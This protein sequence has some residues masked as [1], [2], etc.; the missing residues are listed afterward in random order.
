MV[1]RLTGTPAVPFW[2]LARYTDDTEVNRGCSESS[3]HIP[4]EC[5]KIWTLKF[6]LLLEFIINYYPII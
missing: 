2:N 3:A 1:T 6:L 5:F 4:G